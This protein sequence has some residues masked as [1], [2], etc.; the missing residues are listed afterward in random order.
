M[1]EKQYRELQMETLEEMLIYLEKLIPATESIIIELRDQR[2][3]DTDEFFTAII[4]G[5]NWTI[6]VLNRTMDIM[7]EDEAVIEKDN[8]NDAIFKLGLAIREHNNINIADVLEV[9]IVPFLSI[10]RSRASVITN[11]IS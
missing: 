2:K 7:N 8:I 10:I 9:N 4:N 3:T 6:E 1:E 5:I 11:K